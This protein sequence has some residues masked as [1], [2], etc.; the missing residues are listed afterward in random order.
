MGMVLNSLPDQGPRPNAGTAV[1]TPEPGE[2]TLQ[3]AHS[4]GALSPLQAHCTPLLSYIPEPHCRRWPL[5]VTVLLFSQTQAERMQAFPLLLVTHTVHG[6]V[7]WVPGQS[8]GA[9]G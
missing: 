4:G 3:D 6:V 2:S 5:K 1:L 9:Q 8:C 7:P